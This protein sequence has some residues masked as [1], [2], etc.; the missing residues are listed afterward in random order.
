MFDLL[1][2]NVPQFV[3]QI[4]QETCDVAGRNGFISALA[5]GSLGTKGSG[6][7][8][9]LLHWHQFSAQEV[10]GCMTHFWKS[11]FLFRV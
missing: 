6:G 8:I 4:I 2:L 10:S 9:V 1:A 7:V 3:K 5:L 11:S